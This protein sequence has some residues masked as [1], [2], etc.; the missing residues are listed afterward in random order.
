MSLALLALSIDCADAEQLAGF[1]AAALRRPVDP[2][3]TRASASVAVTDVASTGPRLLFHQVPEPKTVKNRVH[4]DLVTSEAQAETE[5]LLGLGAAVL[6]VFEENG[7]HR[8]TTFADPE[9]NE[10]DLV[11]G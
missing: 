11:T 4:L 9:G 7:R 3:A 1:W 10:F 8:W 6:R 2:G 5:R